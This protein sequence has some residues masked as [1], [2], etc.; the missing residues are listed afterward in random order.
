[1]GVGEGV[2]VGD[3]EGTGV[4][5]L[6]AIGVGGSFAVG[7]A[8]GIAGADDRL[9]HPTIKT[10]ITRA[11]AMA[12]SLREDMKSGS[13]DLNLPA[14]FIDPKNIIWQAVVVAG[15][16]RTATVELILIPVPFSANRVIT[17]NYIVF[18]PP[19]SPVFK[20]RSR[21]DREGR[22]SRNGPEAELAMNA[23]A[24]ASN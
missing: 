8:S 6:V 7:A 17:F 20:H 24:S 19:F 11:A 23:R 18:I 13:D 10:A 1:M 21:T 14:T 5:V 15:R 22:V 4:N 3:G 16:A 2:R 9:P 12:A